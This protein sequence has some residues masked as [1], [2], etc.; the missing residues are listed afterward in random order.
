MKC[1]SQSELSASQWRD[2]SKTTTCLALLCRQMPA[3]GVRGGHSDFTWCA[4][5]G[6]LAR[7]M[8]FNQPPRCVGS[9]KCVWGLKIEFTTPCF[10]L[11]HTSFL[12]RLLHIIDSIHR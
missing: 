7:C 5:K 4:F 9:V 8:G 12:G 10:A 3:I 11:H 6:F 2:T 1:K